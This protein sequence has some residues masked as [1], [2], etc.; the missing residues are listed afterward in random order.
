MQDT[1]TRVEKK[2]ARRVMIAVV[3]LKA[4]GMDDH[5]IYRRMMDEMQTSVAGYPMTDALR[6]SPAYETVIASIQ[7]MVWASLAIL[8]DAPHPDVTNW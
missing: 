4:E 6:G 7:R 3:R 2:L 5:A 1:F 8:E